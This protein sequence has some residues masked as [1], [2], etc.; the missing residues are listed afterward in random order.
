M[1]AGMPAFQIAMESQNIISTG[2][3]HDIFT[4]FLPK[5]ISFFFLICV[6]F[7]FLC[8]VFRVNTWISVLGALAY[9]Y[10]SYN[11][12]IV[13][14]GH[15]TKMLAMA[16][17]PALLGA[18]VLLYE[19]K[20]WLGGALTALFTALLIGMNHLQISYYFLIVAGFM[21]IGYAYKWIKEKQV[22]HLVMAV[23]IALVA[24]ILGVLANATNI[25]VTYDY[26]KATMRNGTLSLDTA[27][28]GQTKK[29]GLPIDY[30]FGW[31]YG[32]AETYTLLVPGVYGGSSSGEFDADSKLATNLVER[33]V[34]E[35]QAAQFAQSMPAYWGPQPGTSGPVYLGAIICFLFLFGMVYL[36]TWHKWWILAAVV[37]TI[38]MSWGKNFEGFNTF[39]FNNLPCHWWFH[40]CF[41]LWLQP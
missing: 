11:P 39:L 38:I 24:G 27:A 35:D 8:Q 1:F 16:Y 22:K 5:P 29:A 37:L 31:S 6:S 40:N 10:A 25:F 2:I 36:K 7:Y 28:N 19:G 17:V 9:G 13:A 33:G 15:D 12:V 4:L 21:S 41:L 30:A 23:A 3:F 18:L 34:P 20:Y 26:S 32:K 14:V